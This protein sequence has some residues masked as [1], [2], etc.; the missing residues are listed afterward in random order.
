MSLIAINPG[1]RAEV[2]EISGDDVCLVI[3]DF[4]QDPQAL[5]R[6]AIDRGQDFRLLGANRF[7]GPE[8][9]LPPEMLMQFA[10]W[11]RR[12][13]RRHLGLARVLYQCHGRLSVV[14]LAPEALSIRQ[15]LCHLDGRPEEIRG[16]ALIAG[17][18]YL[19]GDEDLGGTA[20]YRCRDDDYEAVIR[21]A[22]NEGEA[23]LATEYPFFARPPGYL[24]SDCEFF[25][26][27]AVVEAR[28]NRAVF[29]RGD[30]FHS[31]HIICPEKLHPDPARGRLTANFF[32]DCLVI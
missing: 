10:S 23:A 26:Q 5:R 3:D 19:F 25:E 4:L 18:L 31:G 16:N 27:T 28:F 30:I 7:P 1:A 20:F 9:V 14:S 11:W 13:G 17:V 24:V 8:Y 12:R 22:E 21:R 15:R 6:F 2:R 29:Y 32:L